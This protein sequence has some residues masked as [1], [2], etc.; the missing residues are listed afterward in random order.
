MIFR[1]DP[2]RELWRRSWGSTNSNQSVQSLGSS[3]TLAAKDEFWA[4]LQSNYN[5]IMDN[6]L[7]DTCKVNIKIYNGHNIS[8]WLSIK[9]NMY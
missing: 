8:Y 9:F 6:Q 4:A 2:N 3:A 1:K 5:Y 7:I